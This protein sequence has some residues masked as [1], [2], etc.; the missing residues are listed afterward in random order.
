M[1]ELDNN[2]RDFLRR[3]GQT[4]NGKEFLALLEKIKNSIDK[5]ST[6]PKDSDYG[7]QVEGR[8]LTTEL[9]TKVT[10]AMNNKKRDFGHSPQEFGVDEFH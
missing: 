1:Y 2:E 7:A 9:I 10:Q 6:I 4:G 3:F 5:S 8:R